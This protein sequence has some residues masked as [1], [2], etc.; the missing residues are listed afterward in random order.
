MEK[1]HC[2][3]CNEKVLTIFQKTSRRSYDTIT[4]K[5][6]NKLWFTC[7]SCK[8]HI[9]HTLGVKGKKYES[10]T[11]TIII[12]SLIMFI[13]F[14]ALKLEILMLIIVGILVLCAFLLIAIYNKYTV[15]VKL[16]D[17]KND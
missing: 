10:I 2:P 8:N 3:Y 12:L 11:L 17:V 4:G 1:F 5:K 9:G 6:K 15:F 16:E 7:P 14:T 13:V